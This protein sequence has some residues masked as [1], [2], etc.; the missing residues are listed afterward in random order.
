[1]GRKQYSIEYKTEQ[2]IQTHNGSNVGAGLW[3]EYSIWIDTDGF[4]KIVVSYITDYSAG[5]SSV[6]C[7]WSNDGINKH[8]TENVT[9]TTGSFTQVGSSTSID[10]KARF[11]KIAIKNP[12]TVS[13]I[14]SAW[15]YLK[16]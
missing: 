4:D 2:T 9:N 3:N 12:D 11:L 7:I 13:H 15:V 10:T 14:M 16:S 5:A 8:I 1:M 6:Q